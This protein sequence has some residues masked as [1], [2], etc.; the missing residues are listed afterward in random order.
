MF[1]AHYALLFEGSL[2]VVILIENLTIISNYW[3]R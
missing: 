1:V 2:R 3:K